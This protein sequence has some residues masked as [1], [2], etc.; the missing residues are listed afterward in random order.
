MFIAMFSL[1]FWKLKFGA[2]DKSLLK[3]ETSPNT[4]ISGSPCAF[5]ICVVTSGVN[6]FKYVLSLLFF[7]CLY[8]Y[9]IVYF[10]IVFFFFLS[11]MA[12]LFYSSMYLCCLTVTYL[13]NINLFIFLSF[14][15][16]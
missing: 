12:N 16:C 11:Y 3:P 4:E 7:C 10:I 1:F 5:L 14:F 9:C 6:N 13:F 2:K 15:L 8:Q